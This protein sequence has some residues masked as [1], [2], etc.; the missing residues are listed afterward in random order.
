MG[1]SSH[2]FLVN[3]FVSEISENMF[4][5]EKKE[6][7]FFLL[8]EIFLFFET[9]TGVLLCGEHSPWDAGTPRGPDFITINISVYGF[10]LHIFGSVDLKFF[11]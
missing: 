10:I 4:A 7:N 6:I 3:F 5:I 9:I 1:L 8:R 2:F 11:V